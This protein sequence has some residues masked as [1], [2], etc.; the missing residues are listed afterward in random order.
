M[1]AL[2]KENSPLNLHKKRDK[3]I[4]LTETNFVL[5]TNQMI[6]FY[7]QDFVKI[8]IAGTEDLK[9]ILSWVALKNR[10]TVS[11]IKKMIWSNTI[12]NLNK[13]ISA[14]MLIVKISSS[15]EKNSVKS[16]IRENKGW[17]YVDKKDVRLVAYF[18]TLKKIHENTKDNVTNI[19]L[20]QWVV[21]TT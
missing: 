7:Y 5:N 12:L 13:Q 11:T 18:K 10:H 6:W 8:K 4:H 2:K 21:Y 15:T 17:K 19:N 16:M 1:D 9:Y 20:I 14:N 3:E